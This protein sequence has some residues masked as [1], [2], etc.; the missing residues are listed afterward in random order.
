MSLVAQTVL[1]LLVSGV[2]VGLVAFYGA[3][4][5]ERRRAADAVHQLAP[6]RIRSIQRHTLRQLLITAQ[7]TDL[8]DQPANQA[9]G[10]IDIIEVEPEADER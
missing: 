10:V 2:F 6:L 1:V 9:G 3:R 7:R 5:A 8:M 4:L